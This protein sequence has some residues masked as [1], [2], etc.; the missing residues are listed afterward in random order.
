[1]N[2]NFPKKTLTTV[3][4][5]S[6]AMAFMEAA[7]VIYLRELYYPEGFCF[8]LKMLPSNILVIELGREAATI[9]ILAAVGWLSAKS[10]LGRFAGF[11]I[12][13]GVWDIFYYVFLKLS[14]DWPAG[15]LDWDLLF[16]IPLPWIGPVIAPVL[17]SICLIGSGV[18]IWHRESQKRPVRISRRHWMLEVVAGSIIIGSFL[19]NTKAV[20]AQS[21]PASF[22]WEIFSIGLLLGVIVFIHAMRKSDEP[23]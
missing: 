15:L 4:A 16:L 10:F 14:L 2:D 3:I 5:F 13:F 11:M 12:A 17:V 18:L 21:V 9:I 1:M 23:G 7:V 6:I 20:I 22:R 19:T 8:P